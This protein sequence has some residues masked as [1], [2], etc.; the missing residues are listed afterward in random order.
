MPSTT[1]ASVMA[2][3]E[4]AAGRTSLGNMVQPLVR[5]TSGPS[6]TTSLGLRLRYSRTGAGMPLI[7]VPGGPLLPASY[8][9]DL[10]GLDQHAELVLFNP[11]GSD[12]G[13]TEDLSAYRCDRVADDLDEFRLH[14]GLERLNLLGHS[15]GASI[16]LRYCERYPERVG[17]GLLVA[18][19][20]RAAGLSITD[21]SRAAVARSRAGEPWFADAAAALARI[22][23]GEAL[24]DDWEAIAPFSYGRWDDAATV[25]DAR[26]NK[27]RNP[28]A[29]L[30]FAADGAFDPPSTRAALDVLNVP[31]TIIAGAVDVGLPVAVME[32]LAALFPDAD[33]V[34]QADAGHFPWVDDPATFV[35]SASAALF[36]R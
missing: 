16:V 31:V 33:L 4:A 13:T 29:A 12:P 23:D 7:C 6:F 5:D 1:A 20:T 22:Q 34:V 19:S 21:E 24:D 9:G 8:L 36:A 30:A 11:P 25:F 3:T 14:L 18:P 27:A 32:Q 15:A 10:G 2:G 35:A 17:R 26:M 28:A